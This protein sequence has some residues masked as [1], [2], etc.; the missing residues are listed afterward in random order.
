[1][2]TYSYYTIKYSSKEYKAQ[3]DERHWDFSSSVKLAADLLS[4][5][6]FYTILDLFRIK[7]NSVLVNCI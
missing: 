2:A 7:I 5:G 4:F 1:M 3:I 6:F